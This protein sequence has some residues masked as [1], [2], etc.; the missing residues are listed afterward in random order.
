M[1]SVTGPGTLSPLLDAVAPPDQRF[2]VDR[3]LI[4][5]P[6]L[7]LTAT[8]EAA[9]NILEQRPEIPGV[10]II[11]GETIIGLVDRVSLLNRFSRH[12]MRDYY[13]RRPVALVLDRE[14]L[15][16]EADTPVR[17]LAERISHE[18]PQALTAGF[19]ITRQGRYAGVGTAL[20]MMKA[21]VEEAQL[22]AIELAA[23]RRAA[24][25]A[26]QVKS[27]FLANMSHEIRT[28]MNGILGMNGLLIDTS[29]DEEQRKYAEI[30]QESAEALLA[31]LNDIL[32]ISKL[33]AGRVEFETIDFDLVETVE[34]VV[35]LLAPKARDKGIEL[36]VFVEPEARATFQGD[37]NRIRQILFNLVGNAVKFTEAGS[38]AIEV[39]S[40]ADD[41]R[42][43][44]RLRF[45]VRDTGIGMPEE[46]CGRLFEKFSQADSSITRRYGGT[47]LGLAISKQLAELMGGEIG[48][49]SRPGAGSTFWFELPLPRS[50]SSADRGN[51]LG[52]FRGLRALAIDDIEMN[53]EIVSRQLKSLG[54][55]TVVRK[56]GFDALAEAER[57]WH[58]GKPYDILFLDQMMPD[59]SGEDLA[60]RVREIPALAATKLVLLS[61]AGSTGQGRDAAA[62]FDFILDKPVRQHDLL[63]CV[64][65]LYAGDPAAVPE[66]TEIPGT[67]PTPAVSSTKMREA[68]GGGLSIL[69]AEDNEINQKFAQALLSKAGHRVELAANGHRAVRALAE[70]DFDVVLMDLQMP[71][72]DGIQAAKVIRSMPAP[73]CDVPIIAL[74]AHAMRG[75]HEECLQAGMDDYVSKPI[76]PAILLAKLDAISVGIGPGQTRTAAPAA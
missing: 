33:E 35:A 46:V 63:E 45:E 21:S 7:P 14:P 61:S 16:A 72:L 66:R 28:P 12:L 71:E 62:L 68:P 58:R 27:E 5:A 19:V 60:R 44:F 74:T 51:I 8:S 24:D 54:I 52:Q 23:S 70:R 67:G 32:D 4:E 15:V 2:L 41:K 65:A 49:E 17:L 76:E 64:A 39:S 55:E 56:D 10:V 25:E 22:R 42:R 18:K 36:G 30:V 9:Y 31:I 29:L 59:L 48:V 34:G 11:D 13:L 20:D 38:I 69:L 6:F 75:I 73:K 43:P 50:S 40:R 26:N 57:A 53:L 47:G 1:N 37:P 3:L